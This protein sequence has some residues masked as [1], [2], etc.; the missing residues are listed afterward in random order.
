MASQSKHPLP[1]APHWLSKRPE[2]QFPFE[3]QHPWQFQGPHVGCG[4]HVCFRQLSL[5]CRQ[6]WQRLPP[7][8]HANGAVPCWQAP[9]W[10]QQPKAQ[11]C[12][13]Q[14][15]TG[16]QTPPGVPPE[17]MHASPCPVQFAHC[18]P[19]WP[20]AVASVPAKHWLP[21]QQPEQFCGPQAGVT[22]W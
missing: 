4:T 20:H 21:K 18:A 17:A 13:L 11:F 1:N 3:S 16:R 12:E 22:H 9:L 2:R 19:Y 8:P 6:F 14:P 7:L 5:N 10:S 15:V